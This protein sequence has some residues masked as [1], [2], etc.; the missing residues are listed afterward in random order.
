MNDPFRLPEPFVV[1]FSG[2]RTSG[3]MLRKILDAY[4][5][6][7]PDC[8]RVVFCNTGKERQETLDFVERCSIEWDVPVTWLEY[9]YVAPIPCPTR[10]ADWPSLD[11]EPEGERTRRWDAWHTQM[12]AI[13]DAHEVSVTTERA[14]RKTLPKKDRKGLPRLK[15]GVGRH[16]VVEVNYATAS[17]HGEPLEEI[18]AARNMLPNVMARFC[19]LEGKIR[20]TARFLA[21]LGWTEWANAIGF[22]ADEPHRVAKLGTTN[23]HNREDPRTPLSRAGVTKADVLSWWA[24]Q[25]FDLG[26]QDHEGNCDLCFLKG[27]GKVRRVMKDRSDLAAWWIRM[28][29]SADRRGLAR[30]K[31]VAF[32]R[33]DRPRYSVQLGL[34]QRMDLFDVDESDELS[35]AC[36]C[37]D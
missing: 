4:D 22:R 1:S 24:Q 17:R 7:L 34:A 6:K 8:G 12:K 11:D 20:S 15:S 30:N 27:A 32:F 3:L 21:S 26:L 16:T 35:I 2:G 28:E 19:T 10:S 13:R 37:T 9:R 14:R 5:G 31:S 29:S 23:R 18:I 33:K 36:H 25:P